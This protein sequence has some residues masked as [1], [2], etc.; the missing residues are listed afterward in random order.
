MRARRRQLNA[1]T[2]YFGARRIFLERN[3]KV[4]P[5]LLLQYGK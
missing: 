2:L 5:Q 1:K 3:R 4:L